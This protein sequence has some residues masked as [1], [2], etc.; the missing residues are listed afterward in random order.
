MIKALAIKELRESAGLIVLASLCAIG[1]VGPLIG[2]AVA[3]WQ[4]ASRENWNPFVNELHLS[5][6]G[7]FMGIF[8]LALGLKQTAWERHQGTLYF[9]LHR[10]ISRKTV[11]VVKLL[12]GAAAVLMVNLLLIGLYGWWSATPGNHPSPFF[13]SMTLPSCKLALSM[14]LVYLSG[15]LSGVR[16][17]RWFGSRLVPVALGGVCA[18]V[19]N[20]TQLWWWGSLAIG[21]AAVA[22]MLPAIFYHI[23]VGD[24]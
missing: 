23:E 2:I 4:N 10:P 17:A 8:A 9:L 3:P 1:I 5:D 15:F 22:L 18:L 20:T 21:L 13:W 7:L 19:I 24:Q 14:L 6:Q 12:I 11:F 16:P